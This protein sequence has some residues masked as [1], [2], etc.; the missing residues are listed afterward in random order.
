MVGDLKVDDNASIKDTETLYGSTQSVTTGM[1]AKDRKLKQV[2]LLNW[3]YIN[4]S[5]DGFAV[6]SMGQVL[7]WGKEEVNGLV[8]GMR[9]TIRDVRSLSYYTVK[10]FMGGSW[11]R[12]C[13]LRMEMPW[14]G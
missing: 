9:K 5:L 1:W 8:N 7:G 4:Q 13:D 6:Y 3:H 2:G 14:F 10:W 12:Q 11:R